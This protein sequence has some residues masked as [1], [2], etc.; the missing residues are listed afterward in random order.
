MPL[1]KWPAAHTTL[2]TLGEKPSTGSRSRVAGRRP[3]QAS[4]KATAP[5]AGAIAAAPRAD[6][7]EPRQGDGLVVARLLHGRTREQAAVAPRDQVTAKREQRRSDRS[8]RDLETHYLAAH[9][10]ELHAV[11]F[12]A[13]YFAGP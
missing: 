12:Q 4:R 7:V 2:D 8:G 3:A 1:R 13:T 6:L 9:R 11:G 10:M 5:S